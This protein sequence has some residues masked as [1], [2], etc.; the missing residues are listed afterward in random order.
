MCWA[1][2]HASGSEELLCVFSRG[3]LS[4]FLL[5]NLQSP[6]TLKGKLLKILTA[7]LS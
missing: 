7:F 2:V 4:L 6:G 3:L 5:L 1:H